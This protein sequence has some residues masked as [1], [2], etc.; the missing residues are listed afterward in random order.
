MD[1]KYSI[2]NS[3]CGIRSVPGSS[4]HRHD[5][6]GGILSLYHKSVWYPPVHILGD[7]VSD[8]HVADFPGIRRANHRSRES[9]A[10][11][12]PWCH[13]WPSDRVCKEYRYV[14]SGNSEDPVYFTAG[15]FHD[16]RRFHLCRCR[17]S[18]YE[19]PDYHSGRF[20]SCRSDTGFDIAD[21]FGLELFQAPPGNGRE[22]YRGGCALLYVTAGIFHG[23][24]QNNQQCL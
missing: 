2:H 17:G 4:G 13:L 10:P 9:M 12:Y 6:Y 19:W 8:R 20:H 1:R 14:L 16:R 7:P 5:R 3:G 23:W 18:A 24:L 11:G 21:C 15:H 22:I